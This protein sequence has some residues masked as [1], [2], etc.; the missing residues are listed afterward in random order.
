M[1]M[2]GFIE[3][4]GYAPDA[5]PAES[6]VLVEAR[7]VIPAQYGWEAARAPGAPVFADLTGDGPRYLTALGFYNVMFAWA[8]AGTD[9]FDDTTR[10]FVHYYGLASYQ[11]VEMRVGGSATA[12]VRTAYTGDRIKS[13]L[14]FGK[15]Y[16]A[17]ASS[18]GMLDRTIVSS[19]AAFSAITGSPRAQIMLDV[20]RFVLAFNMIWSGVADTARWACSA[21]DDH[22][23]WTLSPTTLC[24]TG[25]LPD[26]YGAFVAA[27]KIGDEVYAFKSGRV[28]RGRYVPNSIEVF[29]FERAPI[30]EGALANA[31][32]SYR[33][34]LVWAGPNGVFYYNGSEMRNLMDKKLS[35]WWMTTRHALNI[36]TAQWTSAPI[37]VVDESRDLLYVTFATVDQTRVRVVCHIP[38]QRWATIPQ[39]ATSTGG[40]FD[41]ELLVQGPRLVAG[42]TQQSFPAGRSKIPYYFAAGT[43]IT[44]T[45]NAYLLL[46]PLPYD[47]APGTAQAATITTGLIGDTFND[48]EL[49]R[50]DL[51]FTRAPAGGAQVTTITRNTMDDPNPA[52]AAPITRAPDGH[53]DVHSNARFT[54]LK[55]E[56]NGDF[57]LTGLAPNAKPRGRR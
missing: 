5:H 11:L 53:I 24:A 20:S 7:N 19:T 28:Y 51:G 39:V 38:T 9:D 57:Q 56:I 18:A 10:F 49:N 27:G 21:R 17:M 36:S 22:R 16:I 26:E 6:G 15:Y 13:M 29:E 8:P 52:T 25:V 30:T 14:Q 42:E 43:S 50:V 44:N 1:T 55:I 41:A 12:D 45:A 33:G 48:V 54:Q 47:A 32:A 4:V 31:V 23:S 37:V 2:D 34:G 46:R 40:L 35:R 3:F